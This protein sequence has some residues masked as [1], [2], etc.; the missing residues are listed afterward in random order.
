MS[1]HA[2]VISEKYPVCCIS[3]HNKEKTLSLRWCSL[4]PVGFCGFI[5][6]VY[7]CLPSTTELKFIKNIQKQL[8]MRLKYC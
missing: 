3:D 1:F 8:I 5:P 7:L 2:T 4:F 6:P